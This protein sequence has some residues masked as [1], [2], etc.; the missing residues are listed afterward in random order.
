MSPYG[1][2][3]VAKCKMKQGQSPKNGD[4][5]QSVHEKQKITEPLE[6]S[7]NFTQFEKKNS[8]ESEVGCPSYDLVKTGCQTE[9]Q[10]GGGSGAGTASP[11]L[12]VKWSSLQL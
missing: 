12:M 3:Q 1:A 8:P 5:D 4:S 6:T 7:R 11:N 10:Y 2:F 9:K